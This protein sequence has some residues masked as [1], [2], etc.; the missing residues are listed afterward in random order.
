MIP[1]FTNVMPHMR[2]FVSEGHRDIRKV[3]QESAGCYRLCLPSTYGALIGR[4]ECSRYGM[5]AMPPCLPGPIFRYHKGN[6]R[7]YYEKSAL[8]R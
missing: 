4:R 5:H 1:K 2:C 3:S 6:C 7:K 8:N